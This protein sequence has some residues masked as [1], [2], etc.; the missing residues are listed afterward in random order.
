MKKSLLVLHFN[1]AYHLE[2]IDNIGGTARFATA[3]NRYKD[4][5]PLI[6]FGGDLFSPS[7]RK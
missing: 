1:D 2:A 6:I 5:N 7:M 3:L 4:Q